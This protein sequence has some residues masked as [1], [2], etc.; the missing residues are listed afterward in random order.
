MSHRN[1][2]LNMSK[3]EIITIFTKITPHLRLSMAIL[4]HLFLLAQARNL[5]V[6]L[7][8]YFCNVYLYI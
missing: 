5:E 7:D 8:S 1:F 4:T 6:I 3:T 2:K